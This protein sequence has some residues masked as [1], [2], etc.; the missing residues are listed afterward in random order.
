MILLIISFNAVSALSPI[1]LSETL[2]TVAHQASLSMEF[3][4]Q[5]LWSGLS[6]PPPGIEPESPV[7]AALQADSLLV[8]PS[9]KP[10]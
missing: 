10:I 9:G 4:R 3:S 1:R 6:F 7:S 2:W 5:N 8:E